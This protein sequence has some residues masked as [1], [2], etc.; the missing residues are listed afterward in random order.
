MGR[1]YWLVKDP[2]TLSFYRFEEEEY[3]ILQSLDGRRSLSEIQRHFEDQYAPQRLTL[4]ELQSLVGRLHRQSLVTS[5]AAEQGTQLLE[6]GCGRRSAKRLAAWTNILCIR[7]PGVNPDCFLHWLHGRAGWLFS[8]SGAVMALTLICSALLLIA[9]HFDLFLARLPSFHSFFGG[10]NWLLLALVLAGTKVL[11]ELGHG[12]ACKQFGGECHEM[13][14]ML[15]VLTPCL[16]CDVSDSWMVPSKWQRAA[17]GAAGMYVEL[18]LASICTFLWWFSEPG[19]VHYLSLDIMFVCSISTLL[20]NANPLLRY[21]G[22]FILSDLVEIPNLRQ[23][24]TVVLQH[25]LGRWF[26]GIS[27][28]DDPFLPQRRRWLFAAYAVAAEAYRWIVVFS[29]LW[30]LYKVFE[31]YGLQILG[32]LLVLFALYGLL[33]APAW[34]LA[35]FLGAPGRIGQVKSIRLVVWLILGSGLICVALAGPVPYHVVTDFHLQPRNATT[36]YVN[37]AGTLVTLHVQPGDRVRAG[38]TLLELRNEAIEMA[39]VQLTGRR[40][41][42]AAHLAALK[43]QAYDRESALL[44]MTEVTQAIATLNESIERRQEEM[45]RLTIRAPRDGIVFPM[46]SRVA[47]EDAETLPLWSGHPLQQEN[48]SAWL[49]EGVAVCQI[50]DPQQLE[51]VLAVDETTSQP[52]RSNQPVRLFP[53]QLRGKCLEGRIAQVSQTD[54][55]VTPASFVS[56]RRSESA[57]RE[58]PAKHSYSNTYQ[59]SVPIDLTEPGLLSGGTG[60]AKVRCGSRTVAARLWDALC[61]TFHFEL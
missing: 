61:H 25:W 23:K 36:V 18:I 55:R 41:Q 31:P 59:A 12:L 8:P 39:L 34:R 58:E 37:V 16:Y 44:E 45:Q 22:Y 32:Q 42:L 30:F 17:I 46:P 9:V 33:V 6:R 43:L 24:A 52:V 14:L 40:D 11:H 20:F 51:A 15:L 13:G 56:D 50:G 49:A 54:Q 28:A 47:S 26:L 5:D 60:R 27:P 29:I 19:L 38:Q 35:R 7:F 2:L 53:D 57:S 21:D 4:A 48:L 10:T 1:S 3:S